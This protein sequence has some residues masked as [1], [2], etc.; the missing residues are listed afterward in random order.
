MKK[1]TLVAAFV[2]ISLLVLLPGAVFANTA[3]SGNQVALVSADDGDR[4]LYVNTDPDTDTSGVVQ[5]MVP[6]FDGANKA[7][8]WNLYFGLGFGC[9]VDVNDDGTRKS[10][11][12][13]L[14]N[15]RDAVVFKTPDG[16]VVTQPAP[17][18][19]YWYPDGEIQFRMRCSDNTPAPPVVHL[20]PYGQI[21]GP[22]STNRYWA[23]LNNAWSNRSTDF[24][25]RRV[26]PNGTD[27]RDRYTVPA[28]QY[29]RTPT[30][31]VMPDTVMWIWNHTADERIVASRYVPDVG[32]VGSCP[33]RPA[34]GFSFE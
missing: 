29:F 16:F 19:W 5:Y 24:T 31:S 12:F 30:F 6:A 26:S 28:H 1:S 23:E 33:A 15:Q 8:T 11:G 2:V 17:P 21:V 32:W 18:G 10:G 22:C 13:M 9:V 20:E 34:S 25:V 14:V 7:P 4:L 27:E 3:N